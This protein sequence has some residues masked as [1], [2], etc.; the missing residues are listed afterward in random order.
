MD[1][2]IYGFE[3][4]QVEPLDCL[5]SVEGSSPSG[6]A[7]LDVDLIK[8][9][10]AL[11]IILLYNKNM[12]KYSKAYWIKKAFKD[13]NFNTKSKKVSNELL[14]SILSKEQYN[15]KEE[16][17]LSAGGVSKLIARTFPN[18]EK[19][20]AKVCYYILSLYNKKFCPKCK[21][22]LDYDS[23]YTHNSRSD[24]LQSICNNCKIDYRKQNP[25][26]HRVAS[27]RNKARIKERT[28]KFDQNGI[29]AFYRNC[30]P[31]YHVDHIIP[32]NWVLVSG[33]HVLSNLQYLPAK[34]NLRKN[35]TYNTSS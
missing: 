17:P 14:I 20:T 22:V 21:R 24:N 31:G 35:N 34:D 11:L 15:L 2:L 30:P 33:L 26:P 8:K 32:L 18:R 7:N 23:F 3:E 10:I 25:I 28:P 4:Q 16:L 29:D 13:F 12:N 9:S 27:K 5:S 19:T 6:V 1:P